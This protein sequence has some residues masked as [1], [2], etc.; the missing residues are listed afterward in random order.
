MVV[1]SVLTGLC[2]SWEASSL[3]VLFGYGAL[4]HSKFNIFYIKLVFFGLEG[5][6]SG[7]ALT[8]L[9]EVLSSVPSNYM[10]AHNHL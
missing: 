8:V 4:W 5:W 7:S 1:L 3:L 6:L 9:P 10:E 2:E